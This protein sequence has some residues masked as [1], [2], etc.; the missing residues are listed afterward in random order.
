MKL[1]Q[2]STVDERR[3]ELK[4]DIKKDEDNNDNEN[5]NNE[6]DDNDNK[7]NTNKAILW[8]CDCFINDVN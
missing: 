7:K 2:Y 5:N 3:V 8:I 1:F 4:K 6:N